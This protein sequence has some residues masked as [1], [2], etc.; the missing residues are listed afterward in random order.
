MWESLGLLGVLVLWGFFGLLPW[1]AALIVGR[2]HGALVALPLAFAAGVVG[3][4]LSPALGGSDALGFGISLLTAMTGGGAASAVVVIR[5]TNA[6]RK[7]S[8]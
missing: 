7:E 2:G 4:A 3:G 1:C 6:M 5:A 8:P